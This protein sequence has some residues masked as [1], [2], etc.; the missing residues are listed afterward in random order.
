M[1]YREARPGESDGEAGQRVSEQEE[2]MDMCD[3]KRS[4]L[5][6]SFD[7]LSQGHSNVFFKPLSK[8]AGLFTLW[9]LSVICQELSQKEG[10]CSLALSAFWQGA[11]NT[12]R[13]IL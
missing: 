12:P 8:G 5:E 9:H 1:I 11:S 6:G 4:P 7:L 2:A 3:L 13:E 10:N